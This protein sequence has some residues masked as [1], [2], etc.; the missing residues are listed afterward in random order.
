MD[1]TEITNTRYTKSPK[2]DALNISSGSK[3]ASRH[4]NE[5]KISQND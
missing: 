3:A 5:P 4:R 2:Y 1:E